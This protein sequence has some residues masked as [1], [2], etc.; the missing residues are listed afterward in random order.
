MT[1]LA[2]VVCR[3]VIGA[4]VASAVAVLGVVI[5]RSIGQTG[6][7]GTLGV[8]RAVAATAEGVAVDA[9]LVCDI[10]VLVLSAL[11]Q[12]I[13]CFRADKALTLPEPLGALI[14]FHVRGE[15]QHH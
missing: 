4:T 8:V 14:L 7:V 12:A 5:D 9:G 10:L 3:V 2:I 13:S 1:G 15:C 11:G 6:A